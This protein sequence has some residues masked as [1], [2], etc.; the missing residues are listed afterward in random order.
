MTKVHVSS[1]SGLVISPQLVTPVGTIKKIDKNTV[2]FQ[3]Y[4]SKKDYVLHVQNDDK[5]E[6]L[7]GEVRAGDKSYPMFSCQK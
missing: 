1:K 6:M 3:T 5:N 7:V 4:D 2:L